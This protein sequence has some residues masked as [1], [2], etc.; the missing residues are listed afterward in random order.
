MK[1]IEDLIELIMGDEKLRESK[2]LGEKIY[3][4]E[5]I[6]RP[7]SQLLKRGGGQDPNGEIN[8]AP[9][10]T[11]TPPQLMEMR[12]MT[13]LPE[14]QW[15]SREWLFYKQG[16]FMEDYED[17]F[18]G[19]V[20]F[21]RY[22]PTYSDMT[23]E[24]QRAYFAWRTKVRRGEYTDTCLSFMFLYAYEL[25]NLIG[26]KTPRE[27]YDRLKALLDNLGDSQPKLKKYVADWLFDMAVYY[28]LDTSLLADSELEAFDSAI[29]V[30]RDISGRSREEI[31]SALNTLSS[32][33]AERS[34]FYREHPEDMPD[35]VVGSYLDLSEYFK[36]HRKN[37][38]F[39]KFF[40]KRVCNV[41]MMFGSAVFCHY[42]TVK[43]TCVAVNDV[44]RYIFRSGE[45]YCE[46]YVGRPHA[47]KQV[48]ELLRAV[49]CLMRK[50]CQFPKQLQQPD[51][52]KQLIK[53]IEQ[54]IDRVTEEK[55]RAE[56]MRVDID[57]TKL[58]S[59]RRAADLTRDK[60][61]VE[62]ELPPFEEQA[63]EEILPAVD[64]GALA[65]ETPLDEGEYRFVSA[66][67]Y[68]GDYH[69]AAKSA[70][71]MPSLLADSINEK[72][73]DIFA[74]TVID[75]DG[76]IPVIIEDYEEELKGMI[77]P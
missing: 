40:G 4:D 7:A 52:T 35:V 56:A 74:D 67:L 34:A 70:G 50:R 41:H 21:D 17:D 55:K 73:Y 60:L 71:S 45:W 38:L 53:M 59:I 20:R 75:H 37:T 76:E 11:E 16:R 42:R 19:E 44:R 65:N 77:L 43:H 10:K 13:Y 8:T 15:K 61:I 47:N 22:Y 31:F 33:N 24:Q 46:E 57:L 2:S 32:Y 39:E 14:A 48:G 18:E 23:T 64:N 9:A 72:L 68:G 29:M 3:R 5:P 30:L 49:D 62:E 12:R 63:E 69:A 58:S 6:L 27:G 66:L 36:T 25:I 1:D 51:I 26:V 54:N 28:G